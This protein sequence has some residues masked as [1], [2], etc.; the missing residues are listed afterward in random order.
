MK[1]RMGMR[2][3]MRVRMG[4]RAEGGG[5]VGAYQR[6]PRVVNFQSTHDER[7][8]IILKMKGLKLP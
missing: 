4:I 1:M 6:E 7:M 5:G 8:W 3:R 2:M